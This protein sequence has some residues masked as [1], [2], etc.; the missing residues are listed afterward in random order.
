[1]IPVFDFASSVSAA[2][3]LGAARETGCFYVRHPLFPAERCE[4]A[5]D[6]ARR[7]F[8]LPAEQKQA[9]AIERSAHFRGYSEMRN[10]RDWREQIHFSTED[11]P[12]PL[13][14]LRGPN[15]WPEVTGWRD[16]ILS[17]IADLEQVGR[18]VLNLL[19][20]EFLPP[21]ERP[22]LLLKLI[23]YLPSLPRYGVAPHVDFSWITLLLQDAPGLQVLTPGGE[24]LD[25]PPIPGALAVNPGEILEY[26]TGGCCL[27]TP[28]R[29]ICS[30]RSRVSMPFFL[31]PALER[32]VS[33]HSWRPH[34]DP[35]HIHRVFID[36]PSQDFL[37]GDA[38]WRRKGQG[39]WCAQCVQPS[40]PARRAS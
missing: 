15:L 34:K 35:E 12:D 27:A 22:Y 13:H 5:L 18:C 31:N 38:E 19:S 11:A 8:A 30:D 9:C 21:E 3:L 14:Q 39:V 16:E 25:V 33:G 23:H 26:A 6:A 10:E 2:E 17:T 24:W 37:F 20:A 4:Q 1:V 36:P 32:V 40:E 28:H 29:V 7:F